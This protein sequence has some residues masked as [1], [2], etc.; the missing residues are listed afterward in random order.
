M[1]LLAF[2]AAPFATAADGVQRVR[3]SPD[4]R[5]FVNDAATFPI[6]FTSGPILGG[7]APNGQDGLAY[8]RREGY[9]FQL[10]YCP[11]GAWGPE[12][13]K[14]LDALLDLSQQQGTHFVISIPDLQSIKPGE[15]AKLAELR[16]VVTKYRDNPAMLFWKGED[17]PQ[18]SHYQPEDLAIYYK[19]VH[20]LDRNHP[21]WITQAPRGTVDELRPYNP[22]FD[23]GAID[24]YPVSYPP[25]THSGIDNKNLSVVGDYTKLMG[26]V[27]NHQKPLMMILQIC[28]SGVTKPGKTLRFP[29]FPEERYMT[30]QAIIDGAHA[31]VYFGGNSRGCWNDEDA[32][33]G[34]NWSF[35]N[36]VLQPVLDEL[37]PGSPVYPALIAP[38]SKLPV[39]VE[40]APG[41]E[42]SVRES[43]DNIYI[44]AAKREGDTVEASFS[45]LPPQLA[46]GDVLYEAPRSVKAQDGHFTD[47][48]GPNE[49]HIYRF[50][51]PAA[52]R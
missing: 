14:Q 16:R 8:L 25:G 50:R 2:A 48:F 4:G 38:D 12:R 34:W 37:K 9:V 18:W 23:I 36:R 27:M 49:V 29:T 11:P 17:E 20:E 22:Y 47:W 39:Q 6:G 46:E 7:L 35:Y 31:L 21:I 43:G 26:E 52:R 3:L 30:Y 28:W 10:W 45:G 19:T 15:Q 44:L 51:R 5:F 24:I 32:A 13:E 41:L 33:Y 40:G 1:C 42:Y